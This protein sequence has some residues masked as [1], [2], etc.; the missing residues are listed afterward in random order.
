MKAKTIFITILLTFTLTNLFVL[1]QTSIKIP[2]FKKSAQVWPKNINT[3]E[4]AF[5][6][7]D[8][9]GDLDCVFASMYS[10]S[11]VL[12]NDGKG[13]FTDSGQ[14]L[15]NEMHGI[16]IG[17]VDGDGDQDLYFAPI[18]K[19]MYPLY[20]NKGNGTFEKS[21]LVVDVNNTVQ[22]FDIDNDGDFDAYL[23][24][25][26]IL[27][28]DGKG[29][30]SKK[31]SIGF[32]PRR[33]GDLNKD[34]YID[35]IRE[36]A[37]PDVTGTTLVVYLNDKKGNFNEYSTVPIGN[38]G[39]ASSGCEFADI[40][41]DGDK[42]IIYLNY[43]RGY[44][45][46]ILINDGTGKFTNSGQKLLSVVRTWGFLGTGDL[47]GDGSI[48]IVITSKQNPSQVWLNNG[49]G[50]F[51]DSGI[52]LGEGEGNMWTN[53]VLKDIDNDGDLDVFI[54]N[55]MSGEH[56]L[57]FNQLIENKGAYLGQNPPGMTPEVFAPGIISTK[58]QNDSNI[59]FS[60]DLQEF[61]F[62]RRTPGKTD[63]RLWYSRVE[64]GKLRVPEPAPFTYNCLEEYPCLSPNGKRLYYL[65]K[66][67]LPGEKTLS[68]RGNIWFV[69]KIQDE[70]GKPQLLGSPL[71]DYNPRYFSFDSNGIL[72]FLRPE[73]REISCAKL[74]D[75]RYSEIQRLP[76]E[77][78]SLTGVHHPAISPDGSYIIFDSFRS[79]DNRITGGLH[80]SFKKPD[81]SWTKAV[82]MEKVL[83][84][85]DAYINCNAR[86]T[87]DGKYIFFGKY[88]SDSV[89]EDF[90]WVSDEIIE[91]LR[92]EEL[93]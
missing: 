82:S 13:N 12:L 1:A 21:T 88:V 2:E 5:A 47:N 23:S 38:S 62:S 84:A 61:F 64:K 25:E 76:E 92:P 75:G 29:N 30:F 54:S 70:W 90:Y 74:K 59:T 53:C 39:I 22:L 52:R 34:G 68:E 45:S 49:K 32:H 35:V 8:N 78:N 85:S 58:K 24:G 86:I 28:N 10:P 16:A 80:I 87:P 43:E 46:G 19:Q 60:P 42:D 31:G 71:N 48:D 4:T 15:Q 11:L 40:D 56:G 50:E 91:E 9:D 27:L 36:K 41:G 66:R 65:S 44:P 69:D 73:P 89:A 18:R 14:L 57:W 7:L 93:K 55:R 72:Y 33:F 81:G 3:R 63:N 6:D 51:A 79:E 20:F 17:D 83:K 26:G 67:P 37:M 77:I